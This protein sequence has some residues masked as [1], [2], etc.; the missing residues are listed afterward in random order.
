MGKEAYFNS[1]PALRELAAVTDDPLVVP[2]FAETIKGVIQA[3]TFL[4]EERGYSS[5]EEY[6][7]SWGE[8]YQD[9]CRYY[10]NLDRVTHAWFHNVGETKREG[11]LFVRFKTQTLYS[12][13]NDTFLL[14]GNFNDSFHQISVAFTLDRDMA[15]QKA[16]GLLLRA[17][18]AVCKESTVFLGDL[19]GLRLKGV[20]KKELANLLGKSQGCVHLIDLTFDAAQV[21]DR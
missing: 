12:L 9:S 8:F 10:S 2:L 6:E 15:V 16:E 20:S 18:D 7:Q 13:G 17:P 1:G 19:L 11:S 14:S 3:E 5:A 4:W 21:L